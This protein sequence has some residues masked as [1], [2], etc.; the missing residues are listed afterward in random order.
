MTFEQ[1]L[2]PILIVGMFPLVSL[3]AL[4]LMI[5]VKGLTK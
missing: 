4:L 5:V 1:F 2:W 3:A